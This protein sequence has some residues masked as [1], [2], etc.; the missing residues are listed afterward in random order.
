MTDSAFYSAQLTRSSAPLDKLDDTVPAFH[1]NHSQLNG[2][3]SDIEVT[4]HE[5]SPHL[6]PLELRDQLQSRHS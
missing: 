2:G 3:I 1:I 6:A 5:E 4:D